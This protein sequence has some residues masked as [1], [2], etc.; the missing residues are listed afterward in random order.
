MALFEM[1]IDPTGYPKEYQEEMYIKTNK[2]ALNF[3][4]SGNPEG[5]KKYKKEMEQAEV[6]EEN[7]RRH[8]K[9]GFIIFGI[10]MLVFAALALII[11]IVVQND[12]VPYIMGGLAITSAAFWCYYFFRWPNSISKI[13]LINGYN[14]IINKVMESNGVL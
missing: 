12:L 11:K 8:Y 3:I 10:S 5:L 2:E 14:V 6:D 13:K 7:K 9:T 4:K 1:P